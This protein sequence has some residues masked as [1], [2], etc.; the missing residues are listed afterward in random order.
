MTVKGTAMIPAEGFLWVLAKKKGMGSQWWP[1]AG[2]PVE[3][4]SGHWEAV[5]YFGRP[6]DVGSTFEIATVVVNRQTNEDLV[7]WFATAK[8]LDYPPIPFPNNV[9]CPIETVKVEKSN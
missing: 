8:A 3:I 4:E 1:Q 2:G 5:V 7:K 9:G 6:D